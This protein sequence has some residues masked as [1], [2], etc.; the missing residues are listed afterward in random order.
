M[1]INRKLQNL[2]TGLN[3]KQ[4]ADG[5]TG[6][7]IPIIYKIEVD[8]GETESVSLTVDRNLEVVDV[9]CHLLGD[10]GDNSNSLQVLNGSSA[11]TDAFVTGTAGDK[12]VVR[13]GE[14]DDSYYKIGAGGTL[15][16]TSTSS[17]GTAPAVHVFVLGYSNP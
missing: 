5:G 6:G 12:D 3:T 15:K 9:W 13:C 10:G 11:I 16:V 2:M 1:P 4:V 17:D 14:I 7:S 8:G